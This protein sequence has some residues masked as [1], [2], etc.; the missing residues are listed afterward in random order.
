MGLV[1]PMW[2][3]LTSETHA[4]ILQSNQVALGREQI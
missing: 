2:E 4:P 1:E 3:V